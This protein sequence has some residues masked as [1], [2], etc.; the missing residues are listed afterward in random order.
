MDLTPPLPNVTSNII[1]LIAFLKNTTTI[2]KEEEPTVNFNITLSQTTLKKLF[3]RLTSIDRLFKQFWWNLELLKKK[4]H[5]HK[6]W[7]W[8]DTG[9]ISSNWLRCRCLWVALL[10]MVNWIWCELWIRLR[11]VLR[12]AETEGKHMIHSVRTVK[13]QCLFIATTE[14][15]WA[16][17]ADYDKY[18]LNS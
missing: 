4:T 14:K 8:C 13:L 3:W 6:N 16:S 17:I 9:D 1:S 7:S 12:K 10:L 5:L 15:E 2:A 18:N 11:G